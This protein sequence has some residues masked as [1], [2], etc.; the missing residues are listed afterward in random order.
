MTT[1]AM[2]SGQLVEPSQFFDSIQDQRFNL[3][4]QKIPVDASNAQ[5]LVSKLAPW[6]AGGSNLGLN[7][8]TKLTRFRLQ[9]SE[10]LRS[11]IGGFSFLIKGHAC[12]VNNS[13]GA[14]TPLSTNLVSL[15]WDTAGA[16]IENIFLKFNDQSDLIEQYNSSTYPIS[17]MA[18][19]L[20]QKSRLFLENASDML[21]TPCIETGRDLATTLSTESEVRQA[22]WLGNQ[23]GGSIIYHSKLA[24][25]SYLFDFCETDAFFKLN[26]L[27]VS[28]QWKLPQNILF[29]TSAETAAA[30]LAGYTNLYFVDECSMIVD[31]TRMSM[32]MAIKEVKEELK[33]ED[34]QRRSYLYYDAYP[35][36]YSSHNMK[37]QLSQSENCQGVI[38][39]F[40]S[41][42]DGLGINPL[43]FITN[44]LS[45]ISFVYESKNLNEVPLTLD[46]TNHSLN[47]EQYYYYRRLIKKEYAVNFTNAIPAET[48]MLSDVENYSLVCC[49]V[50]ASALPVLAMGANRGLLELYFQQ[51][52]AGSLGTA[53]VVRMRERFVQVNT[54]GSVNVIN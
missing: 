20:T 31:Q 49:P 13:T 26:I 45:S 24:P 12:R 52:S 11:F 4:T 33:Q 32:S 25:L 54:S 16:L 43:Q 37:L 46:A 51:Q 39:M 48:G 27:E 15:P 44:Q 30:L 2:N 22:K 35:L 40:P 3:L 14:Q 19:M 36:N 8:N 1:T 7:T 29:Q 10:D 18:R 34:T 50:F 21:F 17:H 23:A 28:V 38:F 42:I 5:T 53:F 41:T 6:S 47:V 9:S